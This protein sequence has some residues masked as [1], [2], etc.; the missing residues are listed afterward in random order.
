MSI[1]K[2]KKSD[3]SNKNLVNQF[4]SN[5]NSI[6]RNFRE[7]VSE[8]KS[9]SKNPY[10]IE[11]WY[12]NKEDGTDVLVYLINGTDKYCNSH[13]VMDIFTNNE[14]LFGFSKEEIKLISTLAICHFYKQSPEYEVILNHMTSPIQAAEAHKFHLRSTMDTTK[15]IKVSLE[16]IS[17]GDFIEKLSSVDAYN[18]GVEIGHQESVKVKSL[19]LE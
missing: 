17:R 7:V 1:F 3:D 8:V 4:C 16:E 2:K 14:L 19:N 11:N 9:S 5:V 10:K 18:I 15:I 13:S 6:Y 12:L